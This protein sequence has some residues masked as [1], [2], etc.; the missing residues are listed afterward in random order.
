MANNICDKCKKGKLKPIGN[1]VCIETSVGRGKDRTD[2]SFFQCNECG[3]VWTQ[4]EDSGAGGHG[5]FWECLTKGH[6]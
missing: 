2:Y 6:F 4:Y 5:R 3:S 1:S